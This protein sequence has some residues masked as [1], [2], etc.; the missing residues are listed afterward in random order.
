MR[1]AIVQARMGSTRLPGKVLLPLAGRPMLAHV[2]ERV[3]RAGKVQTVLVA[4]STAPADDA[5]EQFCRMGGWGCFRGD[6]LDV[7]DRFHGA[8]QMAGAKVIV[9][10]TAD[11]PLI[12]PGVIDRAVAEFESSDADYAA[13]TIPIRTFPRGLDVEVFRFTALARA[14]REAIDPPSRE[15]VTASIYRRPREFRIHGMP[16]AEDESHHRW[17]VDTPVDYAL[18]ERIY[19]HFDSNAFTWQEALA[20][21]ELHPEWREINRHIEQK[22]H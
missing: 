11:C 16:H 3:Q 14:W 17:T 22:A 13:N 19:R 10:I 4:T 1:V 20:L 9:R 15:H 21:V 6:E 8:A 5:I 7:L 2:C 18:M 12:D